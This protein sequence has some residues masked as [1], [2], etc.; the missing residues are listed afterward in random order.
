MDSLTQVRGDTLR[1]FTDPQL[2]RRDPLGPIRDLVRHA[3]LLDL[4]GVW[5]ASGHE[6]VSALSVDRRLSLDARPVGRVT[7]FAQSDELDHLF[8]QM[9]NVREGAD[10]RRLRT[11]A[12]GA[13]SARRTV[14]LAGTV[15][16]LVG[17]TLDDAGPGGVVEVIEDLGR[18]LPVLMN[19]ELIGVPA[20]DTDQMRVWATALTRQITKTGQSDEELRV[21]DKVVEEFT[22]Y[23]GELVALRRHEPRDDILTRLV[24]AHD[25]QVISADELLAFV[26]TLFTNGLDTL[27][28]GLGNLL[29]TVLGRP[30]LLPSLTDPGTAR[31]AFDEALRLS[32]PVRVAARTALDDVATAGETIPRGAVVILYWAAAN[33]DPAFVEDPDEFRMDRGRLK[34]YAFGHGAHHCLGAPLATLAGTEILTQLANRFPGSFVDMEPDEVVWQSEMPFCAPERL[35]V[36]LVEHVK[37]VA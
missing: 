23:V 20:G 34:S 8:G 14:E 10:H 30:G 37:A 12:T 24:Q 35:P 29:W 16:A 32:S 21:V 4:N 15:A 36:R 31:I 13:F 18:T 1:Y 19:C 7:R 26:I 25:N 3:P 9:L 2:R 11:L 6:V 5:V 33:R 17:S 28:A 27:T 22:A